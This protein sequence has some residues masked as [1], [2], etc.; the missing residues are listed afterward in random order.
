MTADF[1]AIVSEVLE[2]CKNADIKTN[3]QNTN[4]TNSDTLDETMGGGANPLV[5]QN[6]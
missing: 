5:S 1:N 2:H 3:T 6:P 4:D